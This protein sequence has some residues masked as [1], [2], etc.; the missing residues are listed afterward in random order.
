MVVELQVD[1]VHRVVALAFLRS[2][3]ERA[4]QLGSRRV[5]WLVHR[6]RDLFVV[7]D[8]VHLPS[9]FEEVVE[10]TRTGDVVVREVEQRNSR[11]GQRQRVLV[12]VGLDELMLDDPVHLA[13]ELQRIGF[14]VGHDV[15]PHFERLRFHRIERVTLGEPQGAVE[16]LGLD[17][18]GRELPPVR[19]S[20][21]PATRDVVADLADSAN[22]VLEREVSPGTRLFFQHAQDERHRADLQ[23]RR[24][25]AHVGVTDDDVQPAESF[26]VSVRFVAGVDDRA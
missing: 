23:E 8:P 24:V 21:S 25:L 6:S 16:V 9:P 22:R 10:R 2:F 17:I 7:H 11:V 19:E 15:F 5:G 26:G 13:G 1:P 3:D 18:D 4:A 14:E 12:S 20:H